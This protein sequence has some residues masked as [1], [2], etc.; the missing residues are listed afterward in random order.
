MTASTPAKSPSWRADI[1]TGAF[2]ALPMV[3]VFSAVGMT[4]AVVAAQA[5]LPAWGILLM[6][7]LVFAGAAQLAALQLLILGVSPLSIILAT[8]VINSRFLPMSAS[9]APHLRRFR[10]FERIAYAAQMT[11][12]SFAIHT[13]RFMNAPPR[14]LEI[15]TTHVVSHAAWMIGTV[16]GVVVGRSAIDFERFAIDFAMPAIFVALLLPMVRKRSDFAVAVIAGGS[17]VAFNLA[18]FGNWTTLIATVL[19]VAVVRSGEIWIKARSS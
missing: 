1:L 18:G 7:F 19:T 4:F 15:F 11:D 10:L 6:S 8:A 13:V 5:G 3:V 14:R 2:L 9:I 17:A 12:A 16:L